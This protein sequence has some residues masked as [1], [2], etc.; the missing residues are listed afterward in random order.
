[1]TIEPMSDVASN[2]I[3]D[4][5]IAMYP[6]P[7]DGEMINLNMTD[8]ISDNVFVRIMDSM[9]RVVYTNRFSAEGSLNTIVTF[10]KPLS[11]GLYLLEFTDGN[12][13]VTKRMIVAK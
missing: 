12:N 1:M 9:G 13:V 11:Q 3:S 10:S 6:N 4:L 7:N 5:N 8:I 2:P